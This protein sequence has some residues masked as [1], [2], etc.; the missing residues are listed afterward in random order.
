MGPHAHSSFGVVFIVLSV[1]S[2]A[3]VSGTSSSPV[4]KVVELLDECHAKVQRDLD[5]ESKALE[6]YATFCDDEAKDKT[7]AIDTAARHLQDLAATIADAEASIQNFETE[8]EELGNVLAEKTSELDSATSDRNSAN[9]VFQTADKEMVKAADQLNGAM[10]MMKQGQSFLQAGGKAGAQRKLK[11]AVAAISAVVNAQ[12]LFLGSREKLNT[13][14]QAAKTA[15]A[16]DEEDD[17][18]DWSLP[19]EQQLAL[20]QQMEGQT[21]PAAKAFE[22]QGGGII[23]TIED[24]ADKAESTLKDLRQKEMQDQHSFELVQGGLN[25]EIAHN[26]EKLNTAKE[27]KAMTEQALEDSNEKQGATQRSKAADEEYRGTLKM[28]CQTAARQWE[29]RETSAKGEMAAIAKAKE[30][31]VGGV[32]A[33][34]QVATST[35]RRGSMSIAGVANEDEKRDEITRAKFGDILKGLAQEH[36]SFALNQLAMAAASDPFVKIRG[37]V[38]GMIAKLMKEAQEDAT[39]E[40]FCQE[41]MG[42]STNSKEI[43]TISANKHKTRMDQATTTIAE[44]TE[45]SRQLE[46]EMA[47]IDK[48]QAEATK[49]REEEH[50]D[51]VKASTDYRDSAEAVARAIEVLK[52]Y[53]NGAFLQ[54]ASST[55]LKSRATQPA[56]GSA[57]GDSAH[58]IISVL[59]MAQ[60][61]FTTLLAETEGAESDAAK[62]YD[63]LAN[64]NKIARATKKAEVKGKESEVK[65]LKVQL[66]HSTEDFESV[67]QELD[68]VTAYLAKLAPECESKAMSYGERKSAREAEIEGLKEALGILGAA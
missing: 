38:E 8:I 64:E 5:A 65:S 1:V 29:E 63:T 49:V 2:P 18:D 67:S 48:A 44:L 25:D 45:A 34:M 43:K 37:L 52:N 47:E 60:E 53:Y 50:E 68:A 21:Q 32:K 35:L 41:E 16:N 51:Y 15:A 30:I 12:G 26:N 36:Q 24:M 27:G 28:E 42:K 22:S 3:P 58:T 55:E 10:Q 20:T 57:Q 13:F 59:E 23:K 56:F 31:L 7:Y 62:A 19:S 33:F 4:Q 11:K 17:G 14:L 46:A 40:A 6:E 61:D 54:V 39:H 66:A 9:K